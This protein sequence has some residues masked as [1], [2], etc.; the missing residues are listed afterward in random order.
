M[1]DDGTALDFRFCPHCGSTVWFTQD[2]TPQLIAI[3]VGAFA[4][5]TF[6]TPAHSNYDQYRHPWA[7]LPDEMEQI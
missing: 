5:P 6:P 7:G 1:G 4:D 3:A 2:A